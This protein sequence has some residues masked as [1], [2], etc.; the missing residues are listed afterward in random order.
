V[1][2]PPTPSTLE[3]AASELWAERA[4]LGPEEG[5]ASDVLVS[6]S[7]SGLITGVRTGLPLASCPGAVRLGGDVCLPGFVN[8]HSHAFHRAL[9]GV[10]ETSSGSFWTWRELMYRVA[11]ELDPDSYRELAALVYAE[12]ALAGY[13]A[14]GEFHYLHHS[15]GGVPYADPNEMGLSLLSAASSAGVRLTLID[16]CYLQA[17]V[18]GSPL[19]GVQLRFGDGSGERWSDRVTRLLPANG[20]LVRFGVAAHSVRAT[21]PMAIRTVASLAALAEVPLH[22]HLSE[23]RRENEECLKVLG[24]TPTDL[25]HDCGALTGHTTAVHATHVTTMDIGRLGLAACGVCACPT[26]ERDLGDGIGPFADL[27]DAGAVISIGSDSQAVIDPFE[28]TRAI[29]LDE[30]LSTE[31]RGVWQMA[32]LLAAAT[33]GGC[34]SLGWAGGGIRV[35]GLA[36]V[37]GIRLDSPRLAGG[38]SGGVAASA[39][40]PFG[41]APRAGAGSGGNGGVPGLSAADEELLARIVFA[42][43]PS[44]IDTVVVGGRVVVESGEHVTMGPSQALAG[45]LRRAIAAVLEPS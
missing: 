23:Q 3:T 8:A 14:V 25:L 37:V 16:A 20:S 7:S 34:R 9:R 32:A 39:G 44:D 45:R 10:S 19:S 13:S 15:E 24:L 40:A 21:P 26:T 6:C 18:D 27:A 36:D 38:W 42:G 22:V 4:W 41:T 31:R 35:G 1:S 33:S 28:E 5:F 11:A 43:S 29:E 17:G 30:R 2:A 12:M